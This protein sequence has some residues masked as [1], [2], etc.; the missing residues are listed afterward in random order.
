MPDG[1]LETSLVPESWLSNAGTACAWPPHYKDSLLKNPPHPKWK[2]YPVVLRGQYSDYEKARKLLPKAEAD[3]NIESANQEQDEVDGSRRKRRCPRKPLRYMTSTDSDNPKQ[4]PPKPTHG[5][6]R[7]HPQV[8]PSAPKSLPTP[9]LKQLRTVPSSQPT[10]S[11]SKSTPSSSK[12]TPSS[13]KSTPSSSKSTPSCSKATRSSSKSTPSSSQ[14]TTSSPQ[15]T[16]SSS[17]PTPSSS[18]STPSCSKAT[19][20][21]SQPTPSAPT[22]NKGTI[23]SQSNDK[24]MVHSAPHSLPAPAPKPFRSGN[25]I[26]SSS[27]PTPSA[28]NN[29]MEYT[30]IAPTDGIFESSFATQQSG[31]H[32][33]PSSSQRIELLL[34][35]NGNMQYLRRGEDKHRGDSDSSGDQ[36]NADPE[37]DYEH[38]TDL[39]EEQHSMTFNDETPTTII[40]GSEVGDTDLLEEQ[41]SMT[42]NDETPTTIGGSEVGDRTSQPPKSHAKAQ[43]PMPTSVEVQDE[44]PNKKSECNCSKVLVKLNQI[45]LTQRNQGLML[46]RLMAHSGLAAEAATPKPDGW[47][48]HLPLPDKDAFFQFEL[49]LS[50]NNNYEYAVSYLVTSTACPSPEENTRAVL[51]ALISRALKQH[52]NWKGTDKKFGLSTRKMGELVIDAVRRRHKDFPKKSIAHITSVWLRNNL[53]KKAPIRD[54]SDLDAED[55]DE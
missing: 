2:T 7:K 52:L 55:S 51:K 54:D 43:K 39:L 22:I 42:F 6:K 47:P 30:V 46:Q 37:M 15:P 27:K 8:V 3:S 11:S 26:F 41:H 20:S 24:L 40:G 21:S 48:S 44:A 33:P 12:S 28:P 45:I 16:P 53:L 19:R 49:F 38:D 34:H 13:S 25:D 29:Q 10:P 1:S 50:N 14:P 36:D 4:I 35:N 18:Q 5:E 17:Q 31:F 32:A 9:A 23:A